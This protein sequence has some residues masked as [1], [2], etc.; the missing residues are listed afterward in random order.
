MCGSL[1]DISGEQVGERRGGGCN[2]GDAVNDASGCD[3][4][5]QWRRIGP[6]IEGV[7]HAIK[8]VAHMPLYNYL[9]HSLLQ[10]C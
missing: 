2:G 8:G 5:S 1:G 9:R 4:D 6:V 7:L 10:Q 3:D